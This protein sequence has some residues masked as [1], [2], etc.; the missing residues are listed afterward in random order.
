IAL[1][2]AACHDRA[3]AVDA[4]HLDAAQVREQIVA[5][6]VDVLS[7]GA[8]LH[9]LRRHDERIGLLVE[10]HAYVDELPGP[11]RGIGV[12]E[13]RAQADGAGARLARVVDE[14][15]LTPRRRLLR[16]AR[17]CLD[18]ALYQSLAYAF[19]HNRLHVQWEIA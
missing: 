10:A 17:Q 18:G 7:F 5:D 2:E 3:F 12:P 11:E 1:G 14:D 9:R 16:V 8:G 15:Q 6:D 19:M 13:L 4:L